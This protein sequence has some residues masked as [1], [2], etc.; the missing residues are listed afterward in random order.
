MPKQ[1]RLLLGGSEGRMGKIIQDL[2]LK[3][4]DI[5][6]VFG[7]DPKKDDQ[8]SFLDIIKME[9]HLAHVIDVYLNF[10][11]PSAIMANVEQASKLE[12][13]SVIGTTGWYN[14][15]DNVKQ[16][17]TRYDRRILYASNFSPG[18]NVL[19]YA[20][21][22]V[23]RLLNKFGYD[24]TV[25]EVHHAGKVDAPSGTAITLGNIL[26]KEMKPKEKLAY[27]RRGK[28]EENVI[29]VLGQRAGQVAGQHEVWFTPRSSYSERLILQHDILTPEILGI[30]ALSGVRWIAEAQ[31]AHKPAGL[32]NFFED[33]LNL[34]SI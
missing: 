34:G 7:F 33:V 13:D 3:S 5:E 4:D 11:V 8:K 2:A 30:G 15:V 25:R 20:T 26:L 32:Y 6:V 10:T 18:V 28:R 1:I 16:I 24:T 19:F 9:K 29:D 31:K 23:A 27:E 17:A 21:R 22:E 12:I 14:Q